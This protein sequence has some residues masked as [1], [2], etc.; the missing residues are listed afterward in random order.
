MPASISSNTS[1]ACCPT[2]SESSP[3]G[4]GA[5]RV[6]HRRRDHGQHHARELAAGGDLAQRAGRHAGVGGDRQL[7]RVPAARPRAR[8]RT[9]RRRSPHPPSPAPRAARA[10]RRPGAGPPARARRATPAP[11]GRAP[12]CARGS[13]SLACARALARLQLL[14]PRAGALGVFEHGR[15]RAAVLADQ[16]LRRRQAL[17][18][19]LQRPLL[20]RASALA[21]GAQLR[22]HSS[23]SSTIAPQALGERIQGGVDPRDRIQAGG[24]GREQC[25]GAGILGATRAQAPG[26]QSPRRRTARPADATARA[27]RAG[28]RA[29]TPP[30]SAA[31]ISASSCSS[32]SSSR[33]RAWT[34]RA[35]P[36]APPPAR[37]LAVWPGAHAAGARLLRPAHC[38]EDLQLSAGQRQLA[39][40]VLAVERDERARRCRAGR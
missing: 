18:D 30:G 22:R 38:V 1:V 5:G 19:L 15:D 2:T 3:A 6:L 16:P 14:A 34:A 25:H 36:P 21:V 27:R 23:D 7:D 4:A 28:A 10:R 40:L 31:S 37:A 11:A 26:R 33:S 29:R 9:G 12:R 20:A 17:F 24:A 35:A 32:R 39:V 13:C 8:A